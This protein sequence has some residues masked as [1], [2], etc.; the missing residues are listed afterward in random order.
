VWP[1]LRTRRVGDW[2]LTGPHIKNFG[3]L[4]LFPSKQQIVAEN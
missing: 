4:D 1:V 3:V 2:L